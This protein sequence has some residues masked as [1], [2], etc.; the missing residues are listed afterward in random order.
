MC[1]RFRWL[2]RKSQPFQPHS[3]L[4]SSEAVRPARLSTSGPAPS[5]QPRPMA[6][7]LLELH[8][9]RRQTTTSR[10]VCPTQTIS[11][12]LSTN[13]PLQ[14]HPP[15]LSAPS[16]PLAWTQWK[17]GASRSAPTSAPIPRFQP[18]CLPAWVSLPR[19]PL[20]A[21]KAVSMRQRCRALGSQPS[22]TCLRL[23]LPP[24]SG[25]SRASPRSTP[26]TGTASRSNMNERLAPSS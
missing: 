19:P 23:L 25:S 3:L 2:A 12:S 11:W 4:F 21:P 15:R 6:S 14:L 16:S 24:P 5:S 26:L 20:S 8:P 7:P 9:C 22:T 18:S 13:Q 1:R 10:P 17:P